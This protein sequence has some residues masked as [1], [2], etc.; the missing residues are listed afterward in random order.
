MKNDMSLVRA[1][2]CCPLGVGVYGTAYQDMSL[3]VVTSTGAPSFQL[4]LVL[5]KFSN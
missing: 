2:L 5:F 4:F 1:P 3:R